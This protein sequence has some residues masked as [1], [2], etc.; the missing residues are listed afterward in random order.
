MSE[1]TRVTSRYCVA[2]IHACCRLHRKSRRRASRLVVRPARGR[3]DQVCKHALR[4]YE[5]HAN[6]RLN[7]PGTFR[8]G[9]RVGFVD[10]LRNIGF[11]TSSVTE[12]VIFLVLRITD[13]NGANYR[14]IQSPVPFTDLIHAVYRLKC[15]SA[16]ELQT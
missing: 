1:S 13:L 9:K 16:C 14:L 8:A 4:T 15:S 10:T 5:T 6:Y 2:V 3:T 11:R 7:F 12:A